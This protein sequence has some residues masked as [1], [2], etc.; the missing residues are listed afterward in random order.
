MSKWSGWA[1]AGDRR[2]SIPSLY[3]LLLLL[4]VCVEYHYLNHELRS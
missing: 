3:V 2:Y 4:S 1:I